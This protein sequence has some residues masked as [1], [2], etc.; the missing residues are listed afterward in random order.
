ME[1]QTVQEQ[2]LR[3]LDERSPAGMNAAVEAHLGGCAAC[4]AFAAKQTA[5]DVQLSAWLVPPELSRVFRSKL[6]KRIVQDN[7]RRWAD[8]VPDLIHFSS[9]GLATLVCASLLPFEASFTL[10]TG[11]VIALLSYVVLTAVR[12]VLEDIRA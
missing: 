6:R 8:T 10:A 7:G 11:T 1:C 12:G 5:L 4:A 9:L 2:I 3:T